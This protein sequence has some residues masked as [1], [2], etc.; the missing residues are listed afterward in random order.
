MTETQDWRS[1]SPEVAAL[2]TTIIEESRLPEAHNLLAGLSEASVSP[3]TTWVL[4]IETPAS[5]AATIFADGPFPARAFVPSS[6]EYQGE[7]IIWISEGRV[8]GIEYAWVTDTMPTRW[9]RPDETEI[10]RS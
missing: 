1:I 2:I 3:Q 6:A 5:S 9:P 7:V 10:V 8:S 4:D